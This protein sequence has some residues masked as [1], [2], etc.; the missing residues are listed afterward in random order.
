MVH[1]Q[2]KKLPSYVFLAPDIAQQYAEQTRKGLYRLLPSE[3]E[4]KERYQFLHDKGYSL[5]ARYCPNWEPS[6]MGTNIAPDFCEDSLMTRDPR[7]MDAKKQPDNALVAI[8]CI[9]NESREMRIVQYLDSVGG[10]EHH[11]V[12]VLDLFTDPQDSRRS[13]LIMPFLRP[14]DNPELQV[15]GD[16]VEFALQAL[17]GLAFLHEHRIAHRDIAPT[18]IMMDGTPLFPHGF[19]PVRIHRAADAIHEVHPLPRF[20]HPVKYFY[21]DFGLSVRF[22]DGASSKVVGKVGQRT[23]VPEMSATLPY[24]AFKA[25]IYALGDIFDRYIDQI[26][27]LCSCALLVLIDPSASA[28]MDERALLAAPHRDYEAKRS[29]FAALCTRFTQ[30]VQANSSDTARYLTPMAI[31]PEVG[32]ALRTIPQRHCRSRSF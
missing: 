8:K 11:C 7:I 26:S 14:Y 23:D 19:H 32:T 28:E 3:D 10:S 29:R 1:D 24:D 16:V 22:E 4:W 6:W 21:I 17:E 20:E 12:P 18:N 25:D 5:R 9:Q 30:N 13:L 15:V 31:G 27:C 2:T